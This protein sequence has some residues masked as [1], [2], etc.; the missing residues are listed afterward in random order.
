MHILS[1][2]ACMPFC[3]PH[4]S[5]EYRSAVPILIHLLNARF[6]RLCPLI[7][8]EFQPNKRGFHTVIENI[9]YRCH[10]YQHILFSSKINCRAQLLIGM[11]QTEIMHLFPMQ[12]FFALYCISFIDLTH[13]WPNSQS[14]LLPN[15]PPCLPQPLHEPPLLD[16]L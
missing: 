13:R 16:A 4:V 3:T 11:K 2:L 5:L 8:Q 9:R 15:I 6:L 10:I 12:V 14:T 7:T 1:N